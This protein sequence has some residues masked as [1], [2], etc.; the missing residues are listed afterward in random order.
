AVSA[1]DDE[2]AAAQLRDTVVG[3]EQ[4]LPLRVVAQLTE[5]LEKPLEL[6]LVGLVGQ[7]LDVLQDERLRA[8]VS[9]DANILVE[10]GRVGVSALALLLQPEPGL[11]ERGAGRAADDEH[12][13]LGA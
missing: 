10:Q 3:G 6:R 2:D 5:A 7:T 12:R 1:A 13:L 8:G 11:G 9:H 4:D